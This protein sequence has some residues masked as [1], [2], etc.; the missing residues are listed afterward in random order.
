MSLEH[1]KSIPKIEEIMLPY[2]MILMRIA[3][4][5][6][7]FIFFFSMTLISHKVYLTW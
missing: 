6:V 2:Y 5:S 7:N 4:N 1:S 3:L